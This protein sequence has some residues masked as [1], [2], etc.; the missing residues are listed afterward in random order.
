MAQQHL[1]VSRRTINVATPFGQTISFEKGK[2]THVPKQL[3]SFMIEKGILPCDAKGEELDLEAAGAVTQPDEPARL[4][5]PEDADE[6][7]D[8]IKTVVRAIAE[9]NNA[10]DF[11]AGG[12]PK[13]DAVSLALGWKADQREVRQAWVALRPEL[14]NKG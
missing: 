8:A 2:P 7:L 1:F 10:A 5:A 6:R 11:N 3:H 13:A 14:L 9:R 12:T 4:S